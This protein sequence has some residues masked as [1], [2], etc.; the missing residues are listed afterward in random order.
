M[1]IHLS[2]P[3]S[4]HDLPSLDSFKTASQGADAVYIAVSGESLQVLGTGVTPSGRSVTW[5][6]P[7][8]D[9]TRMFTQALEHRFGPGI[10]KAIAQ[11]L[12]LQPSP[13]KPLSARTVEQA[14]HMAE[15]SSQAMSGVDF[16]TQLDCSATAQGAGFQAVCQSLGLSPASLTAQQRQD[17]D[18][19]MQSHFEQAASQGRSPVT[20]E[21]AHAW[22]RALLQA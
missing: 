12:N 22:L 14:L 1:T 18:A 20:P 19:A 16:I 3:L 5:V 11:E 7:D 21:T 9:T 17:I 4:S 15:T 13:G 10:S 6:A 2:V 8:M